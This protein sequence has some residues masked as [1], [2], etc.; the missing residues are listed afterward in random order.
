MFRYGF[1][2]IGLCLLLTSAFSQAPSQIDGASVVGFWSNAAN[3]N[4]HFELRADGQ[5]S[6]AENG[7]H[8]EGTWDLQG[9][10]LAGPKFP[11]ADGQFSIAENG[12]HHEGTWDL[13][14]KTL[15]LHF[16]ASS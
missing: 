12:Q 6:I 7:Q 13:Q 2:A 11:R 10:S 15:A 4:E 5:F 1:F 14:G 16:S 8:H 9:S 3:P